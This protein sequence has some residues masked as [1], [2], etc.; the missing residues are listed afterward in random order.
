MNIGGVNIEYATG[1]NGNFVESNKIGIGAVIQIVRSGDVIPHIK[2]VTTPADKAKM[3][4]VPYVWTTSHVDIILEN[5]ED[6]M[7]VKVKNISSFF[8]TLEVESLSEGNV[9]RII[10]AGYD[11]IPKILKMKMEDFSTVEGFKEKLS[12][13]ILNSIKEKIEKADIVKIAAA[14]NKLGRGI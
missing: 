8:T 4:D 13:K 6:D 14:S 1:F 7:S 11:T 2:S 9:S 12:T 10:K 5:K 3:P